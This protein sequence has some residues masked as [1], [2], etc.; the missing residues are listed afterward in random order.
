MKSLFIN[1][2]WL[3]ASGERFVSKSPNDWGGRLRSL[4]ILQLRIIA[5]R[6]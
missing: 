5:I 1:N 4:G 2:T 6:Q 3:N